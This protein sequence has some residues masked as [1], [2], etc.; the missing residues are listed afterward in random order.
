M[1]YPPTRLATRPFQLALQTVGLWYFLS[2]SPHPPVSLP[3]CTQCAFRDIWP[4]QLA[5]LWLQEVAHPPLRRECS[6]AL[7]SSS[8]SALWQ[9]LQMA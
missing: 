7:N 2:L 3:F 4:W 6:G 8:C 9:S 1:C 5:G